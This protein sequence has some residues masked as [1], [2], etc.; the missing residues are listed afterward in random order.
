MSMRLGVDLGGTKIEIAA[1]DASGAQRHR[2]RVA[3]PAHDYEATVEAI[4]R[5]VDEAE[6][7]LGVRGT[8]GIGMPGALSLATGLVK[9]A[10]STW[11]NGRA[12]REDIQARLAREV[13]F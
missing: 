3:T 6:R 2:R 1:L 11:L 5:L 12:F 13:R 9:N 10:N 7:E 4:G 8:V